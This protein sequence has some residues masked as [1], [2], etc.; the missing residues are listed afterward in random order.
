MVIYILIAWW[1]GAKADNGYLLISRKHTTYWHDH[2][3]Q[4]FSVN[5]MFLL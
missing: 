5:V 1:L 2:N 3:H 4:F